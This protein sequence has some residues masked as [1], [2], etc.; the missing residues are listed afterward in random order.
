MIVA[1]KL[2]QLYEAPPQ[3]Y[4]SELKDNDHN[5]GNIRKWKYWSYKVLYMLIQED[6]ICQAHKSV[7][8]HEQEWQ[9]TSVASDMKARR[10]QKLTRRLTNA[11]QYSLKVC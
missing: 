3:L 5:N 6:I 9:G 11:T 10:I 1:I 4:E 7:P 2:E 8:V